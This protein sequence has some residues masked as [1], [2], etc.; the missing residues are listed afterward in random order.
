MDHVKA[1]VDV[2]E[3]RRH[4]ANLFVEYFKWYRLCLHPMPQNGILKFVPQ[5]ADV[6]YKDGS[7]PAF[8]YYRATQKK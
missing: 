5:M 3:V 1:L 6:L 7:L 4:E 8:T 2:T